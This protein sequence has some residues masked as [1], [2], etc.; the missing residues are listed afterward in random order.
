M[1]II[2]ASAKI[3]KPGR[4]PS[5]TT[6]AV[7]RL[8]GTDLRSFEVQKRLL[9]GNGG[10]FFTVGNFFTLQLPKKKLFSCSASNETIPCL[11]R[12]FAIVTKAGRF[13]FGYP[14]ST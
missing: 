8:H 12:I 10:K 4:D 5:T 1:Q 3:E 2:F 6:T 13:F 11:N 14:H 9:Q 7:P